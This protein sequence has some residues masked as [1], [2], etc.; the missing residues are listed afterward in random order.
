MCINRAIGEFTL[1]RDSFS[2]R[3]MLDESDWVYWHLKH[4]R[5]HRTNRYA[6]N[7]LVKAASF[8]NWIIFEK[9]FGWGVLLHNLLITLLVTVVL[10]VFL[11]YWLCGDMVVIWDGE[12]YQYRDLPIM[13]MLLWTCAFL[14]DSGLSAALVP[15]AKKW[16][17]VSLHG[18]SGGGHYCRY[19]LYRGLYSTRRGWLNGGYSKRIT[20]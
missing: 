3:S 12:R 5:N 2:S 6:S 15:E 8:L 13:A 11:H 10:F 4:Y 18:R 7:I 20:F 1:L 17:E 19:I 16:W 9:A 14:V